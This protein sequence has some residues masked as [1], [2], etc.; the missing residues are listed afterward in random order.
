[1]NCKIA[2]FLI[3]SLFMCTA[4]GWDSDIVAPEN[5]ESTYNKVHECRPSKHPAAN[6]IV[7]WLSPDSI[8]TWDEIG[9]GNTDVNFPKGAVVVKSQYENDKCTQ[10]TA[11][12]IMEKTD[13]KKGAKDGGWK[14]QFVDQYGQCNDCDAAA[15]CAGCHSTCKVGPTHFCTENR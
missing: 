1:M 14:W 3:T 15:S 2:Y 8:S 12:T 7:T 4:C 5:F 11:Y 9:N 6:Y 13:V 10:L